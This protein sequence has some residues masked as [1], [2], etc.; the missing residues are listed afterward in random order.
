MDYN[1]E[2]KVDKKNIDSNEEAIRQMQND[3]YKVAQIYFE[4]VGE[5]EGYLSGNGHHMAQELCQKAK[6]IWLSRQNAH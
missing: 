3:I 4:C 1:A 2:I 5:H 6:E